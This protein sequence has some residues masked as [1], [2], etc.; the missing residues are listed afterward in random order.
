MT[1]ENSAQPKAYDMQSPVLLCGGTIVD[2]TGAKG[3]IGDLLIAD[4]KIREISRLPID[5]EGQKIDCTGLIVAPGFIDMHSH[6]DWILP[7]AGRPDLASPFIDQ[8][9]TTFVAGNCGFSPAGFLPDSR[10]RHL[11]RLGDAEDLFRIQWTSMDDYFNTLGETG[12]SHNLVELA[13]QGTTVASIRGF[14]PTPLSSDEIK[15][16]LFLLEEAMD[17]GAAGVSLGLMYE[18]GI[19]ATP[20]EVR[21]V[22]RLVKSKD[23]ILTV[24]ARALSVISLAYEIVPDGTPHNVISLQE[25]IDLSKETGVRL[26]YSH[27]MFAGTKSH[28]TYTQCLEVLDK[29]ISQGVDIMID[30]FPYHCGNSVINVILPAWFLG[31]LPGNYADKDALKR[32]KS[33]MDFTTE[34]LGFGYEDIQIAYAGHPDLNPY[35]GMFV[36]EIA[37]AMGITPFEAVIEISKKTNGTAR[38]LNHQYSNMEIVEAL[39]RHPACL[40]MTDTVVCPYGGAQNPATFGTFPLFLQYARDKNLIRME[41]AVKKMTGASASRFNIKNRGVL[42]KGFAAD[43]TVFDWNSV[44][45]NQTKAQSGAPPSGIHSVFLNG[46]QVK[47]DGRVSETLNAG[48]GLRIQSR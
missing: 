2:G 12:L 6:M 22:A 18:P 17:Q 40:F 14:D 11:M 34:L 15:T 38:V 7:I 41:E 9:C 21:Q 37:D 3:F 27:L 48:Q 10:F 45:D 20:E 28:P 19:F 1:S 13:G 32:L 44:K 23:K 4:G 35:N 42:Q 30:S 25:M 29:A 16:L 47:S 5:M 36:G 43:V 24:H 26:Q 31:G 46:Q 8:G 33:G 39:I